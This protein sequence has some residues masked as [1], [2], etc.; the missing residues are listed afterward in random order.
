MLFNNYLKMLIFYAIFFLNLIKSTSTQLINCSNSL[1]QTTSKIISQRI[2]YYWGKIRLL[3][4]EDENRFSLKDKFLLIMSFG[5]E[6]I[7]ALK[8]II[9]EEISKY[10]GEDEHFN[11]I[12]DFLDN[13]LRA[14]NIYYN[15]LIKAINKNSKEIEEKLDKLPDSYDNIGALLIL[16]NFEDLSSSLV[17][18]I[19]NSPELANLIYLLPKNIE[20]SM[21]KDELEIILDSCKEFLSKNMN[22]FEILPDIISSLDNF[23]NISNVFANYTKKN[24]EIIIDILELLKNN[25]NISQ[26]INDTFHETFIE[27]ED[28]ENKELI[29]TLCYYLDFHHEDIVTLYELCSTDK[30]VLK[31]ISDLI[32]KIGDKK[33]LIS[34]LFSNPALTRHQDLISTLISIGFAFIQPGSNADDFVDMLVSLAQGAVIAF[35]SQ[36]EEVIKANFS[37]E[38]LN[39]INFAFLGNYSFEGNNNISLSKNVSKR[40]VYKTIVDTTKSSNDLLT[41]DNCLKKPPILDDFNKEEK[42]FVPAFV[43][44]TIDN[45]VGEN[46]KI[47]KN[48][49]QIEDLYHV[50][51]ICLP[52]G[53]KEG[54]NSDKYLH[55][56]DYEYSL[57]IRFIFNVLT[58]T[59]NTDISI[60]SIKKNQKIT[61]K[62]SIWAIYLGK[63]IPFYII[64]LPFILSFFLYICKNYI[65]I[66]ENQNKIDRL[67]EEENENKENIKKEEQNLEKKNNPKWVIFLDEF[68]NLS[69]NG[70]E[71]FNFEETDTKCN[72]IRGLFYIGGL[73]GI[74]IVL[75]ILGQ[76]YFIL[77]NLPM[78]DFG[79]SN[80]YSLIKTPL[81]I[82]FFVGLR[83]SPRILFSCSGYTLSYKYLDFANNEEYYFI[84]FICR[85]FYK[86]LM[87]LLLLLFW[88]HS[89]YYIITKLFEIQPI[90]ELF[91]QNVLMIPE[92]IPNFILSLLGIS[93]FQ[94]KK[95]DSRVR[96]YLTDY[97]WM[98]YNENIFFHF[99][100]T[101]NFNRI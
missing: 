59:S 37:S 63:L 78:K 1:N 31:V 95:I 25:K 61:E 96:H 10:L 71:L 69:N 99:R 70:R 72:N 73:T 28:N 22:V 81:Y 50:A 98:A 18:I 91:Q 4:D 57:I 12:K 88:R 13:F 32:L 48:S 3:D 21:D 80:F 86:Y 65:F 7:L 79:P 23:K 9:I 11:I 20:Y 53:V 5:N 100:D 90:N 39:L 74:S 85:H 92:D 27:E 66:Y 16:M 35:I 101:F 97:F 49:T 2:P 56:S 46:K 29:E 34:T 38:C 83:Y 60:I 89:Y 19:T 26:F 47:F 51:S 93:S 82:F 41:Y 36:N 30:E 6:T 43:I 77:Y 94:Y 52:Q 42:G 75:T 67:L 64:L 62:I 87:L 55:C 76:I 58:N 14:D 15:D 40:F 84:K 68:L 17:N 24:N 54:I 33:Y 8:S 45:S 44:A